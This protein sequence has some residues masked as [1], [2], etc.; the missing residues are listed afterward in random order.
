MQLAHQRKKLY[1]PRTP[2]EVELLDRWWTEQA[3]KNFY[4]YRMY[5]RHGSFLSNW[6]IKELSLAFQQFYVAFRQGKRPILVISCPPQHGKS[7]A[8]EDAV[9]WF[10]GLDPRLR[11]VF[12]S[13]SDHLGTRCNAAAQRVMVSR[14]YKKIFPDTK[15]NEGGR[16]TGASETYK[17]NSYH[18]EFVGQKGSFRNTTVGGP[19]TGESLDIGF[20]DDPFKGRAEASSTTTRETV[21]NWFTDDFGTRFSDEAGYVIT[22]TRWH[23]DDLVGRLKEKYKGKNK[24]IDFRFPALAEELEKYRQI[25]DPLFPQLKSLGFLMEKKDLFLDASWQS[26]YQ[27]NPIPEGGNIIKLDYWQW[28]ERLPQ[29]KY[30]FSV[31]DTAQKKNNWNDPTVF[32]FWGMGEDGRIYLL[33]MFRGRIGAPEL[34]THAE[35]FYY[36]HSLTSKELY[37]GH[38]RGFCIEDKSSGIGL[39]QELQKKHLKV[40]PIPRSIDKVTR[41][42]DAGPE[43]KAGKV[44]LNA[45]VPFCGYITDEASAFPNGVNDDSFDCTMNAIE[46][47]F[48]YPQILNDTIFVS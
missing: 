42:Y 28:W 12:A 4:A 22:M 24:I 20:I 5:M 14:K 39:I 18:L 7:W 8:V 25:G 48:L 17:R 9:Q 34:R 6:F 47:G 3:R 27:G 38:F 41:A 46:V 16:Q 23:I 44:V 37:G 2:E 30:T 45:A 36:K 33:D 31:A 40:F 35:T 11:I 13:F 10:A 43:I 19:I 29:M 1:V 26:L 32:Q 15:L 21:W